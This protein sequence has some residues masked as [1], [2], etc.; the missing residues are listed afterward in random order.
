[1][2]LTA[3]L[4]HHQ[5]HT[6]VPSPRGVS[7][8]GEASTRRLCPAWQPQQPE[9]R[10]CTG[11]F[12]EPNSKRLAH[13]QVIA[14]AAALLFAI[15]ASMS[16]H[17]QAV[18]TSQWVAVLAASVVTWQSVETRRSAN[19]SRNAV[20]SANAA[21][22]LTRQQAAEAVRARIDAATPQITVH[23]PNGADWP[24][25]Q[26]NPHYGRPP[27]RILA[28]TQ[29]R[30]P[31]QNDEP[32]MVRVLTAI[33]NNSQQRVMI[34]MDE[35]R[36]LHNE[37]VGQAHLEP[38]A[39]ASV[40]AVAVHTVSEWIERL[41]ADLAGTPLPP[42]VTVITYDDP[43][44]TGAVDTWTIPIIGCPIEP[45][46]ELDGVW[47]RA[48]LP[49]RGTELTPPV[50]VGPIARDRQ[51]WLSKSANEQLSGPTLV[52]VDPKPHPRKGSFFARS[53]R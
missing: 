1:M 24:P 44:D 32:I 9:T 41:N 8:P 35:L 13:E 15:T 47:R 52:S 46:P 28:E 12:R 10:R 21:L 20:D 5:Q 29:F 49:A 53:A 30:T 14:L 45:I 50:E 39:T 2:L 7:T 4:P 11:A 6:P 3:W 25:V 19:A 27:Q 34:N 26:P 36:T 43:A 16:C 48:S 23:A 31:Q 22:T 33:T 40:L 51:Y 42:D 18:D 17:A 38:G 37:R